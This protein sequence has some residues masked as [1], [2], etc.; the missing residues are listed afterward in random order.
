[1]VAA[2]ETTLQELLEGS[3]QYQVPLYQR[4]YGWE[5]EQLQRLWDDVEQLAED[6]A[7]R[8]GIT[9]FI[10]SLVLAPSP[11]NGPAGVQEFL[12]IDGQQRLTTL[13]LL[14]CAIRDHRAD[15][16]GPEHRARINEQFLVNK[17]KPEQQR[18]KL[19]PTQAD[20][21]AFRACLDAT[22]EAGGQDPVGRAYR[23]FRAQL[24]TVDDLEDPN[25]IEQIENAVISG[26]ALVS[27]TAQA[28]DNAHRI[29]ESL[30]NTGL[31]LTQGDLLRNYLFMRL[32]A[33]SEVVYESLWLPLQ[34]SLTSEQLELLF[35]L[36]LAQRD[37]K[38]KQT[39]IYSGQQRRLERLTQEEI[40]AEVGRFAVLGRLLRIILEPQQE[41]D[42]V[43]RHRLERLGAWGST[44]VYPFVLYALDRRARG[45]ANAEQ[46][47][48]A[49]RYVESFLVRRLLTG[50]P[51]KNVNRILMSLVTELDRDLPVDEAVLGYLSTGRKYFATDAE[52]RD[53]V[54]TVPFYLHGRAQQRWLVLRWL[55][56]SYGSNEPVAGD[57]LTIEHVLPRTVSPEWRAVLEGDLEAG[58]DLEEVHEAVVH[59]L[60]NLTLT[61]YNSM[62]S[63]KPFAWKRTE[64][65]KSSIRLNQE[66]AACN[67]WGRPQIHARSEGLAERII[68]EWPGPPGRGHKS[69]PDWEVIKRALAALPSGWWTTY[70]DLAALVGAHARVIGRRL[71]STPLPNA[72]RVLQA[73]GR[74]TDG[75]A[76]VEEG[77]TDDPR[78]TLKK[79]GLTFDALGRAA[80]HRRLRTDTLAEL[81]VL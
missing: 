23:F 22:A 80:E 20:R 51:T 13:A 61:G 68:A 6:R 34:E 28:G 21:A 19:V 52:V 72:H 25:D 18:M 70:G 11:T 48:R 41:A 67:R 74:I 12:V 60:G 35:W 9:H 7:E 10:G 78:E 16:D 1:M 17:W 66:I 30:N 5:T 53:A 8:P 75:F 44:T 27:V 40:E 64:L 49:L 71:A 46:V 58:E 39:D 69:E 43:V 31:R 63:N 2:R 79:E 36:D 62:L 3:K 56:E 14:L 38:A 45:E 4:T 15:H 24:V 37:Q 59:T 33:R 50:Q 26:L 77:R 32:G 47:A 73:D 81:A 57:R 42:S 76:W 65:G 55:E 29:F 54:P